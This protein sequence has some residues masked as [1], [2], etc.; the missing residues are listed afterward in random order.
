[1]KPIELLSAED[2]E[3]IYGY[4]KAYGEAGGCPMDYGVI[5]VDHFLRFW[6]IHKQDLIKFMGNKLIA[7]KDLDIEYPG[8]LLWA[9]IESKLFHE[10]LTFVTEF[11]EMTRQFYDKNY[12]VYTCLTELLSVE[13]LC[14]NIYSDDSVMIPVPDGGRPIALNRGCKAMKVLAKI[15]N[16]FELNGFEE[17][18]LRHSMVLNHKRFKGTLCVSIHPL[19][20]MTM[21]DNLYNWDSCMSWQKPGEYRQGT[22]ES[23]NTD[24]VVVTYLKGDEDMPLWKD[25]PT[26]NNKRWRQLFYVCPD[27]V[28]D[29]RG[30]PYDDIVLREEVFKMLRELMETNVP[31]WNWGTEA[32]EVRAGGRMNIIDNHQMRLY[33]NNHIMYND[34]TGVHVM[35]VS[36]SLLEHLFYHNEYTLFFS[37][38]TA[39]IHCGEDWTE[40]YEKFN[41]EYL[42]CPECSGEY[43][44]DHCGESFNESDLVYFEDGD[45]TVCSYCAS[46]IGER[47]TCCGDWYHDYNINNVYLKHCGEVDVDNMIHLC[48]H[49]TEEDC[50]EDE[51][52]PISFEPRNGW[53]IGKR[54]VVNTENFSGIGF[55]YFG[56]YGQGLKNMMAEAEEYKASQNENN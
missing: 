41:T 13:T 15:A 30:Y 10:K 45:D 36:P 33:I 44:C 53:T 28:T 26:W 43:I 5:T 7:E 49:C 6:D 54:Y 1:M 29:I 11:F 47:C 4:M 22:V 20:Y 25:G 14:N 21:S 12:E 37:G 35:Y 34:Y 18:R 51:L 16:A 9:E 8:V 48:H 50:M 27:L 19:D 46:R 24:W 52:G 42:M 55:N 56:F 23:M 2:S 3:K 17:F 39:C 38:E 31:E 32:H 40:R